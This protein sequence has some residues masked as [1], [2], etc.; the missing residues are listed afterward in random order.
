M[1]F[2]QLPPTLEVESLE[3]VEAWRLGSFVRWV[4]EEALGEDLGRGFGRS[5]WREALA[6]SHVRKE[7]LGGGSRR[8]LR[9]LAAW[10]V[11]FAATVITD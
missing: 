4:W 8:R 10:H 9:E 1:A 2:G 11:F 7:A 5:F 3:A 6:R